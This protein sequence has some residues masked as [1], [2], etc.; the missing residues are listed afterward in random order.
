MLGK[1]LKFNDVI[2]PN[3]IT[4]KRSSKTLENVS[5]S[6]SGTDLVCVIRPSK[7]A[8]DFSFNL[9]PSKKAILEG[10][11]QDESTQ[12]EYMGQIYTVRVRDYTEKLAE[13]SEWLLSVNGLFSCSVKVTEF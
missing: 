7:N 11:C 2:F 3:P 13:G 5:Q 10:L 1:Y 8:W 4:P 9:S 6:E 12:M